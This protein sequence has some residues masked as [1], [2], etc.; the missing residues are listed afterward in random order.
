[1]T[2]AYARRAIATSFQKGQQVIT[3]P[4]GSVAGSTRLIASS[5]LAPAFP[6]LWRMHAP[7]PRQAKQPAKEAGDRLTKHGRL[8]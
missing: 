2:H 4:L 8:L 7:A 5:F 1:M 3:L 6:Q